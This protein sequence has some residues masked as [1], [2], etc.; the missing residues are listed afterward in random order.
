[1][2][3]CRFSLAVSAL[4][5]AALPGH[6]LAETPLERGAYLVNAVAACGNCHTPMGPDWKNALGAGGMPFEGP[7]GISIAPNLTPHEDG[8]RDLTDAELTAMITEGK[9]P[10]GSKMFPPMGYGYYA[11]MKPDDVAAIIAYLR[12]IPPLPDPQ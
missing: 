2:R 1:M 6:V 5:F 11:R 12:S 7:W 10:D 9:R 8:I 4:I 3:K